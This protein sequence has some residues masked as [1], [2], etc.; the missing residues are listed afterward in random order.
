MI[1]LE[2]FQLRQL[3]EKNIV[4]HHPCTDPFGCKKGRYIMSLQEKLDDIKRQF[5]AVA[6]PEAL[7][8]MHHGTDNL[9]QSGIMDRILKKG[10]RAP[11]FELPDEKGNKISAAALWD[12]GPLIVGFY[13]G[14]W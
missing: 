13:R 6:P 3:L 9:I 1:L 11:N 5:E 4:Y 14:V 12:N 10:G 2:F 8:A 7:A